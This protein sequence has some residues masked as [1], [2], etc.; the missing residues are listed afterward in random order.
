MR[1]PRCPQGFPRW[2]GLTYRKDKPTT[3]AAIRSI[4]GGFYPENL[5]K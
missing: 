4:D 5:R 2:F 1:A 3:M